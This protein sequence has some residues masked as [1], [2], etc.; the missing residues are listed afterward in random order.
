MIKNS[1][2]KTIFAVMILFFQI[3]FL[4]YP[5]EDMKKL[6]LGLQAFS[7]VIKDGYIYV[8]K[9][10]Y[11]YELINENCVFFTR[12]RR[13][14]RSLLCSTLKEL[15]LGHRDFFKGL[16]IDKNTDYAWSVHPV[17]SFDL[18][19]VDTKSPDLLNESLMRQ[20]DNIAEFYKL[21]PLKH[22]YP[23]EM[24]IS[25]TM[26]LFKKFGRKNR[27]VIIVDEYDKPILD[28]IDK[29]E[30]AKGMQEVLRSFYG[31]IKRLDEYLRFVFIS[32]ITHI[33]MESMFSG[34]SH[35]KNISMDPKYA[36]LVGY[37]QDEISFYFKKRLERIAILNKIYM[38]DLMQSLYVWYGGYNFCV[39]QKIEKQRLEGIFAPFSILIFL[40]KAE[41]R[42]YWFESG[43]P[44]CLVKVLQKKKYPIEA[45]ENLKAG[46][47]ELMTLDIENIS[48]ATI[49]FMT[50]YVTIKSYDAVYRYY[51][52]EAPN[53]EVKNS[54][55]ILFKFLKPIERQWV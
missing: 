30:V 53:R 46:T 17:I 22:K 23:G 35:L 33:S 25:L 39:E 36:A 45:F 42:N 28:N 32:G 43:T 1:Y 54:L 29:I 38:D 2:L 47:N 37:T 10:K 48:L 13:F 51:L 40:D 3:S 52:L 9:T 12:P 8:D 11:I 41:L 16:W 6:P 31:V 19:Q 55:E 18:S 49:L 20:I 5:N 7:K 27:V 15:F 26:S 44:S 50:G 4:V 24:L 34:M 14:G 21:K